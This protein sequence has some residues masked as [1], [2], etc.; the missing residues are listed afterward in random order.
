M[1]SLS[2]RSNNLLPDNMPVLDRF[3][4]YLFTCPRYQF[5]LGSG[6]AM[7]LKT[8]IWPIPNL[9]MYQQMAQHPFVNPFGDP[10]AHYLFWNWLGP[11]LAWCVGATGDIA[12]FLFHL[13]FALAFPL[14]LAGLA[15]FRLED[16]LARRAMLVFVLLPVSATAWFWVGVDALTLCLL[17]LALAFPAR[18]FLTLLTGIALGMQHFEQGLCAAAALVLALWLSQRQKEADLLPCR[19]PFALLFLGSII[20]GKLVLLLLFHWYGITVN[21]GRLYWLRSHLPELLSLFWMHSQAV[22]WSVLGLGWV[23]LIGSLGRGI[24]CRPFLITLCGLLLLLPLSWDQ[25]RVLAVTA[26]PLI[27]V[28]WLARPAFLAQWTEKEMAGLTLLWL[29]LPWS[30]TWG[31]EPKWSVFPHDLAALTDYLGLTAMLPAPAFLWPFRS[32]LQ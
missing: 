19:L 31:G 23:I 26:F 17:L 28:Y 7:L 3:T 12:F 4:Q 1:A 16:S 20:L 32:W 25:T 13:L 24:S 8:G 22:L 27:Y 6:L 11:F 21:A 10:A 9:G 29:W 5:L 15:F 30:W 2:G 14:C 18:P